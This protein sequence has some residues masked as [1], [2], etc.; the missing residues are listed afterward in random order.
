MS[1]TKGSK[2]VW[3]E[4]LFSELALVRGPRSSW[5]TRYERAVNDWMTKKLAH[6]SAQYSPN[7]KPE[8]SERP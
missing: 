8:L 7:L 3:T 4:H 2:T 1:E 5:P 6:T